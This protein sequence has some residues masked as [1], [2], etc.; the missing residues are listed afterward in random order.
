VTAATAYV[1][2]ASAYAGFQLLVRVVVY[3]S[4]DLV[5]RDA[6]P[7][8]QRAH[9]RR[10]TPLAVV[11]F[12]M[13]LVATVALFVGER[14]GDGI[15]AATMFAVLLALTVFGAAPTH[16]RLVRGYD[17]NLVRRLLRVDAARVAVAMLQL[18]LAVLLVST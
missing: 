16:A 1:I 15:A 17:E 6:F 7:P 3:P 13:L 2:A 11:L 4:Y 18:A 10:I 12:G 5:P 14:R 9:M 8:F